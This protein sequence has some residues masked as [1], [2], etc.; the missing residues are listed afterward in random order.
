MLAAVNCFEV[1]PISK[2]VCVQFNARQTV[3]FRI[4]DPSVPKYTKCAAWRPGFCEIGKDFV[5]LR[6][7]SVSFCLCAYAH[8]YGQEQGEYGAQN[9]VPRKSIRRSFHSSLHR[10]PPSATQRF[11]GFD[12]RQLTIL[13]FQSSIYKDVLHPF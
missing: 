3:T 6:S 7:R 11:A 8:G 1:D 12:S 10:L 4:N 5:N 2:T 13:E 9:L